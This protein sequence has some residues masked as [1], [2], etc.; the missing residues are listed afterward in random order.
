M[1]FACETK[2]DRT[3]RETVDRAAH[4]ENV[5]VRSREGELDPGKRTDRRASRPHRTDGSEGGDFVLGKLDCEEAGGRLSVSGSR[6]SQ[7][8]N[9]IPPRVR[10]VSIASP[11]LEL[12]NPSASHLAHPLPV[13]AGRARAA[14]PPA[15]LPL[16]A[17]SP[18]PRTSAA[19]GRPNAPGARKP[20]WRSWRGC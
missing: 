18:R 20:S 5:K 11:Q 1:R 16:D 10:Q 3:V 12:G 2:L 17:W 15:S 8:R 9:D 14:S 13:E 19:A 7:K 6:P 4:A